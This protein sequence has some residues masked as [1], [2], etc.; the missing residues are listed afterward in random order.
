MVRLAKIVFNQSYTYFTCRNSKWELEQYMHELTKT[1][2]H[3]VSLSVAAHHEVQSAT[4]IDVKAVESVLGSGIQCTW[5]TSAVKAGNPVWLHV[6]DRPE[7]TELTNRGMTLFCV[8]V[9][10]ALVAV[11]G[12][13][14]IVR[15]EAKSVIENLHGQNIQCHIVSGD[16]P[17]A[18]VNI[19]QSVGIPV[20]HLAS[21]HRPAEKQEYIKVRRALYAPA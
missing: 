16:G 15:A 19:A 12:F 4:D 20:S 21:C 2:Q 18:V 1:N 17:Q 14:D 13:E 9:D 8:T 3:P 5:R 10:N 6:E 7:I 11:L